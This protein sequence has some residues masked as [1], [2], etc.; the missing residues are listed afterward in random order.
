MEDSRASESGDQD[1]RSCRFEWPWN[2]SFLSTWFLCEVK[3]VTPVPEIWLLLS[4]LKAWPNTLDTGY[5]RTVHIPGKEL[6]S[7][8]Q[9]EIFALWI[10]SYICLFA[11]HKPC[12]CPVGETWRKSSILPIKGNK[13]QYSME[14][15]VVRPQKEDGLWWRAW[16]LELDL[17]RSSSDSTVLP[18]LNSQFAY[19][20]NGE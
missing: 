14:Y 18:G 2:V 7:L 8:L 11:E 1:S 6:A 9:K 20:W 15:R 12:M 16:T 13:G 3:L 4:R 19:L 5:L 17:I 10:Y